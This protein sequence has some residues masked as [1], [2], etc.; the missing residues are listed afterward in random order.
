VEKLA[1]GKTAVSLD[2]LTLLARRALSVAPNTADAWMPA[3]ADLVRALENHPL[4]KAPQ[5]LLALDLQ[6][7]ADASQRDALIARA[8]DLWKNAAPGDLAVLAGWLNSKNEFQKTL[9]AIPLE[10]A[11]QSKDI[12]LQLLD[13]LGGLGRWRELQQVLGSDKFPL[14][15]V[16]QQ[17]YL[18]RCS[19]Q[20]G[21]K[22]AAE[23]NWK[24]ALEAAGGDVQK[25][26]GLAEYAEKN[27][28]ID[29]AEAAY[30]SAS[31]EAPKLRLAHQGRL[32]IAER[33]HDTAKMH[34]VLTE[35]KKTWP[36]DT[37]IQNDE[38][39]TRLL[40]LRPDDESSKSA[41]Q[42]IEH[43]ARDLL[44]REPS[45]LPHR[46]LLA[47]ALLRQ[48]RAAD[49]FALYERLHVPANTLTASALAVHAA[50]LAAT[51][52]RDDA[53]TEAGQIPV[54]KLLPEERA[55]IQDLLQ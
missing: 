13:A 49:A 54:D 22:T 30:D 50:V 44:A 19:A 27:Q 12:F 10:K 40:L 36:N 33:K 38:A 53:R 2:A 18:A 1:G 51:D 35:M 11:L 48:A 14:D 37:A 46:T 28:V 3:T 20:L 25:L 8:I 43:L 45:S 52:H 4:A 26:I 16:V 15:P 39:Y 29:I 47:L 24:R 42:T 34:R 55:L 7:H 9:D 5:K 21:E 31:V 17:M 6:I 32:Q 41:A 23:N